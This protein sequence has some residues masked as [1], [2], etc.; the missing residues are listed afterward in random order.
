MGH[1]AV[2]TTMH[3]AQ[4]L[5]TNVQCSS[6]PKSL[7]KETR[8][9]KMRG[10][11]AGHQRLTKTNWEYHQNWSSYSYSRSCPRT[12]R[13]HSM[14]IR[15]LKQIRKVKKLDKWVPHELTASQNKKLSFW[16]VI[17]SF[18]ATKMN[19]LLI[20]LWHM[21]KSR[22]YMTTGN[23]QLIGWTEKKLQSTSWSQIYTKTKRHDHCLVVCCQSN[24]LWLSE[25]WR[26]HYI[27]EVRFADWWD[28]P[29]TA[30]PAASV[31]QQKGQNYNAW[32]H[33]P[34][35]VLQKRNGMSEVLP[36]LP[37]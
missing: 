14:V 4:E 32:L 28:A 10:V 1:K 16:S 11:V 35:P 34:Q 27:W 33:V 5:L 25:S 9:L 12:Q 22:F 2:E 21:M 3:L 19:H 18:Y 23:D 15:H 24:Q 6:G 36:H 17:F 13:W 8:A 31:G 7:S 37:Y 20:R 29:K 26:N 30:M